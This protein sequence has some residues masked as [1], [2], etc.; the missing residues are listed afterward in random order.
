MVSQLQMVA[1]DY[2][3]T[4][5]KFCSRSKSARLVFYEPPGCVSRPTPVP[6]ECCKRWDSP[7]VGDGQWCRLCV[8]GGM[9][10]WCQSPSSWYKYNGSSGI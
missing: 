3:V 4:F 5:C 9:A 8:I 6:V 1:T 2:W 7:A 10:S